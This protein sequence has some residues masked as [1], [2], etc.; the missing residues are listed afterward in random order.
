[1]SPH[2]PRPPLTC[3]LTSSCPYNGNNLGLAKE[4][5][6]SREN[7]GGA[8]RSTAAARTAVELWG[9]GFFAKIE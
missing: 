3:L 5:N 1:M 2:P 9:L 4:I 8:Q 7:N 6:D